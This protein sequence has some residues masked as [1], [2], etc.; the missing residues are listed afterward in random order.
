MLKWNELFFSLIVILFWKSLF[1]FSFSIYVLEKGIKN[2]LPA[3]F[4]SDFSENTNLDVVLF[5]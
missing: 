5:C 2:N 4:I 1:F 3:D